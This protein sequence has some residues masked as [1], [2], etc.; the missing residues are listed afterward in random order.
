[1]TSGEVSDV[2]R[3]VIFVLFG[4]TCGQ[5][6]WII[7]QYALHAKRLL[8]RHISTVGVV[9]LL[10][11]G[12]AAVQ[13]ITRLGDPFTAYVP[14]NLFIMAASLAAMRNMRR[15]LITVGPQTKHAP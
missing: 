2:A 10:T 6:A 3:V 12:E 5:V 11:L 8:P 13:N 1:M 4:L 15:H 7:R 9:F 14:V